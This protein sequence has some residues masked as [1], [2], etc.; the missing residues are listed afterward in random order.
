MFQFG[1]IPLL[2]KG[3]LR[4]ERSDKTVISVRH[5]SIL[6]PTKLNEFAFGFNRSQPAQSYPNNE[7]DW[8]NF[9]GANLVF[10]PARERMGQLN[11]GDGVAAMGFPR[12]RALFFQNFYTWRD[13]LTIT[14]AKDTFKVGAEYNPMR[15]VMDQ[16]DG[17]YNAVYQFNS[18]HSFL[19]A[20]PLQ[21]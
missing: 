20:D 13:N 3:W 21:I 9:H 14:G 17:S 4:G 6:S 1:Y 15:L 5:T 16:V 18:F 12:D 10:I 7:P 8:K 11:Y 19:T 2:T